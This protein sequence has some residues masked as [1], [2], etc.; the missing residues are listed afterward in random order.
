[1][2]CVRLK[3]KGLKRE[4]TGYAATLETHLKLEDVDIDP[5]LLNHLDGNRL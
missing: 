4:A 1:M 2:C 3:G 5:V